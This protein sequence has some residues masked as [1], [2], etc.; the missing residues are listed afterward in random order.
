VSC[1]S[2]VFNKL[3]DCLSG[4]SGPWD[5]GP[6]S[7]QQEFEIECSFDFLEKEKYKWTCSLFS[8]VSVMFLF[9]FN[10]SNL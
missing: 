7:I 1:F 9:L 5:N 10:I 4:F 2:V 8:E 6:G 3:D